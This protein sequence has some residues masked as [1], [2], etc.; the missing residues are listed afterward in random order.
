MTIRYR[1]NKIRAQ[2]LIDSQHISIPH[3]GHTIPYHMGQVAQLPG[4]EATFTHMAKN[5]INEKTNTKKLTS[6]RD[7]LEKI[8][9]WSWNM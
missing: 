6:S 4:A 8:G 5:R 3:T 9:E 7:K 2:I 1:S